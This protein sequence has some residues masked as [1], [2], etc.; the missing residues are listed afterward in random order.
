M[1]GRMLNK[2]SLDAEIKAFMDWMDPTESEQKARSAVLKTTLDVVEKEAPHLAAELFGSQRTGLAM[3]TSD[4]DIRLYHPRFKGR[5]GENTQ[6]LRVF[7]TRGL[8]LLHEALKNHPEYTLVEPHAGRFPL[9][10]AVHKSTGLRLQIVASPNSRKSR[11]VIRDSMR[12]HP[13]IKT[14]FTILKTVLDMRGLSDVYT[15]GMGS[16]SIFIMILAALNVRKWHQE[17]SLLKYEIRLHR[18]NEDR[19]EPPEAS[20]S[21]SKAARE[22]TPAVLLLYVLDFYGARLNSYSFGLSAAPFSLFEKKVR[23]APAIRAQARDNPLLAGQID[24][25]KPVLHQRYLLCLQDPADPHNDL[26]RKSYAFKHVQ[27]TLHHL[28][29]A[30]RGK[31]TA[32]VERA[33]TGKPVADPEHQCL[34]RLLVG[35]CD[36]VYDERRSKMEL[37]GDGVLDESLDWLGLGTEDEGEEEEDEEGQS[38]PVGSRAEVESWLDDPLE[39]MEMRDVNEEEY[40]DPAVGLDFETWAAREGVVTE[41]EVTTR[42][43]R[44]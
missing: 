43:G 41:E 13:H 21:R 3:P 37:F 36:V 29:N 1:P 2:F 31:L 42:R 6:E 17:L 28:A 26:G 12:Q 38:S 15:G 9:L 7:V 24:M 5:P 40:I 10:S 27:A 23:H 11:L 39:G 8:M 25:A 18:R 34:L 14:L 22:D 19:T 20:H 35:R 30:L 32:D 4:L 44:G 16:Y 33:R